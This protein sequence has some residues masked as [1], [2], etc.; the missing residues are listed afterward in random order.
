MNSQ[1]PFD[2]KNCS[3]HEDARQKTPK[4]EISL[5]RSIY[6]T[7]ADLFSTEPTELDTTENESV[8]VKKPQKNIMNTEIA[9]NKTKIL[10]LNSPSQPNFKPNLTS[11]N[12]QQQPSL[13]SAVKNNDNNITNFKPNFQLNSSHS[14]YQTTETPNILHKPSNTN[15]NSKNSIKSDYPISQKSRTES[16]TTRQLTDI[17]S[18]YIAI[19]NKLQH[20]K[21]QSVCSIKPLCLQVND[22]SLKPLNRHI[23]ASSRNLQEI[24]NNDQSDATIP[25]AIL[26]SPKN[27]FFTTN[28]NNDNKM[29]NKS[30]TQI[31]PI[32]P[33]IIGNYNLENENKTTILFETNQQNQHSNGL[34]ENLVLKNEATINIMPLQPPEINE[35]ATDKSINTIENTPPINIPGNTQN[36]N[37]KTNASSCNE[38]KNIKIQDERIKAR[39]ENFKKCKE[40]PI[41]NPIIPSRNKSKEK[42]KNYRMSKIMTY[43]HITD[44]EIITKNPNNLNKQGYQKME[45]DTLSS[46]ILPKLITETLLGINISEP[47][48][49]TKIYGNEA[50]IKNNAEKGGKIFSPSMNEKY[51]FSANGDYFNKTIELPL[52]KKINKYKRNRYTHQIILTRYLNESNI[53]RLIRL[54]YKYKYPP[55]FEI[56]PMKRGLNKVNLLCTSQKMYNIINLKTRKWINYIIIHD[57]LEKIRPHPQKSNDANNNSPKDLKCMPT[58]DLFDKKTGVYVNKILDLRLWKIYYCKPDG[59]CLFRA[60][61][62]LLLGNQENHPIIR[63][64]VVEHILKNKSYFIDFID[65]DF[66]KYTI[67]LAQDKSWGDAIA[68]QAAS[69]LCERKIE[70]YTQQNTSNNLFLRRSFYEEIPGSQDSLKL[71]HSPGHYDAIFKKNVWISAKTISSTNN[72]DKAN[73]GKAYPNYRL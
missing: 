29:N 15:K 26:D 7:V 1:D 43:Q 55:T 60:L 22:S 48:P 2:S 50:K 27:I 52:S 66:D 49:T 35:Q 61:A 4:S 6:R 70:I 33:N 68:I 11:S 5:F 47:S 71:L 51:D 46:K 54:L 38:I 25:K 53:E 24:L 3:P 19:N 12:T 31:S 34:P 16:E 32:P 37:L 69:E 14:Y 40:S 23:A 72:S 42:I 39:Y 10:N 44:L 57:Y 62:F 9:L 63:K 45:I 56:Q 18:N 73:N 13:K 64:M 17:N 28:N 58:E 8:F 65:E 59:N 67:K 21:S 20:V 41:V 30:N 36:N